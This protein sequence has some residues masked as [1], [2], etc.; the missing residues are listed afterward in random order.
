MKTSHL[1]WAGGFTGGDGRSFRESVEDGAEAVR[2][3]AQLDCPTL[4]ICS[5]PRAGHT[6][7]H[8]R[9]LVQAA[10]SQLAPIAESL[11]VTLAVEPMH[12]G[13]AEQWTF[14]TSVD[15]TLELLDAV[16]ASN[17]KLVLDTYHVG[18]ERGLV[19]RLPTMLSRVALV[20]LGDA[21][22]PPNGEQNRCL[23]GE[24]AV[25][26]AQIVTVLKTGGYKG[27]YDVELLGEEVETA[28]YP[29]LLR[30]AR[31]A[32]RTLVEEA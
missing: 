26:L 16:A 1:F 20:Q 7:N 5:G 6:H 12:Q 30:H 24:G 25:P 15:D 23:L 9:R 3:A 4:A 29:A 22:H 13:C 8:A 27:Y 19:E 2:T 10:L 18:L 14:L 31:E 21:R 17:V 32:F 28:E 11:G